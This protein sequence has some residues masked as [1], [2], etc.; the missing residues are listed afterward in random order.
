MES[1][2]TASSSTLKHSQ[3]RPVVPPLSR[4]ED[5]ALTFR[6]RGY[7]KHSTVYDST[8]GAVY[9][10]CKLDSD[11]EPVCYVTIKRASK[12]CTKIHN[13]ACVLRQLTISEDD[14]NQTSVANYIAAYVDF[15]E[16]SH[17]CYLVTQFVETGMTLREFV[18]QC[19]DYIKHHKLPFSEFVKSVKFLLWQLCVTVEWMHSVKKVSHSDLNAEN[20]MIENVKFRP[21]RNGQVSIDRQ[22]SIK[23]CEFGAASQLHANDSGYADNWSLGELLL[24]CLT[25]QRLCSLL[26]T[27]NVHDACLPLLR[28]VG[29]WYVF[30]KANNLQ[31][32][33][34]SKACSLLSQ[35]LQSNASSTW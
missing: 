27:P 11:G 17:D 19:H 33:V 32:Y 6:R 31:Q 20:V 25:N 4:A 28:D 13:E 18:R 5:E 29:T 2:S 30:L 23:L 1:T 3:Q 21:L 22:I 10:A 35:L 16:S 15:F 34:S 26:D 9:K 14:N 12:N 7:L 24:E 8:Q